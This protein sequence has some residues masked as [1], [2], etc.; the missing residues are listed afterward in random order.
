MS[1]LNFCHWLERTPGA[2][3]I[4]ENMWMFGGL[5][6]IHVLSLGVFF[7]T[8]AILDLRL[9]GRAM[10]TTPISDLVDRS[11]PWTRASFTLMALSGALLLWS[12]AVKCY[13][14]TSFRIKMALIF[15]AG[16]NILVFHRRTYRTV[17]AWD[18]TVVLPARVRLAGLLSLLLW[19]GVLTAGRAVGYDY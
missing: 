2:V 5:I 13:T 17:T 1:I 10:R 12:E 6:S 11:L 14:S 9:L 7:G 8:I 15:L 3:A 4:R 19:I 18:Q 16:F